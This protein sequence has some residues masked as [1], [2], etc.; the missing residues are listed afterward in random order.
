[1]KVPSAPPVGS[2]IGYE[3]LWQSQRRDR[4]DGA[5]T[6]PAAVIL[7]I[8]REG[9]GDLAYVLGIS[10]SP[11]V[12]GQRAMLVPAKLKRHLGLDAQPSWIYTDQL[13]VFVWPGP[14]LR[15]ASHISSKAGGDNTCVIGALPEDWFDLVKLHL[16][17][18]RRQARL[19]GIKRTE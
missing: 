2:V 6:Y 3:Y 7:S 11:P 1:L 9:N 17:E 5:K 14:D 13:N 4:E 19:A 18:S 12:E 15:P 10:H 8:S 16:G